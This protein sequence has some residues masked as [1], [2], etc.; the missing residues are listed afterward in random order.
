MAK[1]P[2]NPK[3]TKNA[4]TP[5]DAAQRFVDFVEA[6]RYPMGHSAPHPLTNF[7]FFAG[8]GF[9]K[10]WDP[11]SPVGEQ[12]FTFD[13]KHF[14]G[15]LDPMALSRTFGIDS[16]GKVTLRD[17]RQ[18]IYHIDVNERFP[19]VRSR[20]IDQQ[21]IA[22]MR[23][24]LRSI[25]QTRF[26]ELAPLNYL[27]LDVDKF[28]LRE[29]SENQQKMIA[30]FRYL[31]DTTDGSGGAAEGIRTNFITTNY[32]Y[33]I[34][35]ILDNA[36][37]PDDSMFLYSYR[38]IT[39][40]QI[41]G[42]ANP[43]SVSQHWLTSHLLKINGGFEI[44]RE[45]DGYILDYSDRGANEVRAKPPV[46]MLPSRE[47]D[48]S[49]P[50]FKAV[51]P[52]AVRLLRESIVLIIVGYS[53]PE[54]DALLRFIL[55]QFAEEPEDGLGKAVFYIDPG[56]TRVEKLERLNQVYPSLDV[57]QKPYVFTYE[58]GFDAFVSEI[59]NLLPSNTPAD[60]ESVLAEAEL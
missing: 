52:K 18:M 56:L 11:R 15:I 46:L 45:G 39:A 17:L 9:S 25:I 19:D 47:Q 20:Y 10:S 6:Y 51:F 7:T 13:S 22:V 59:L 21:N 30:F 8:A 60:L 53:L 35:T 44:L 33:V 12:L 49:D 58:G 3:P 57:H 2:R 43:V 14:D 4:K 40:R 24:G 54:D 26:Q 29:P 28:P 38:G 5:S 55:R 36:Y 27:D 50:Y 37:N 1:K 23:A 42:K 34:E 41:S 32:D 31:L 48:Y 16:F